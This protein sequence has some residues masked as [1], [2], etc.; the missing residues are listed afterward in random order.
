MVKIERRSIVKKKI[1]D[2]KQAIA[3]EIREHKSTFI[4]YTLMRLFVIM[5]AI[6]Q[7]LNKNYEQVFFCILTLSLMI[8]PSFIQAT[9]KI[10]MPS[11]LE[12]I[13]L[14][15]IFSAEIL[16]EMG[17]YYLKISW[18]DT[19]LHTLSGF[20]S[21]GIGFS[22]VNLLND[23]ERLEFNLSPLFLVIVAFCFSMTIGV[24]WEFIEFGLDQILLVDSQKDTIIQSIHSVNLL[25]NGQTGHI[26]NITNVIVN[27]Q[28]LPF[29]GYLDIGL[30]DTMQDLMVNFIGA[31][32]FSII[33][34]FSL[35][36]KNKGNL[37]NKLTVKKKM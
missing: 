30:I 13:L 25:N 36:Y 19:M 26:N 8:I 1:K 29:E 14:L 33:G 17:H 2:L 15:F 11:T 6:L 12:I 5:I 4:V 7:F 9:F 16:G 21:A 35:K 23:D 22:L 20:I 31:F 10:Y 3:L 28:L 27:G 18:W 34:Y 32:V 24:I 37:V